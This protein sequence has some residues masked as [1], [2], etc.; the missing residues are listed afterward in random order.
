M[1]KGIKIVSTL[2][3]VI[4]TTEIVEI[5]GFGCGGG[6]S[7]RM[8]EPAREALSTDTDTE[9]QHEQL[10]LSSLPCTYTHKLTVIFQVHLC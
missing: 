8:M 9:Q 7:G 1:G 3:R 5:T 10:L 6:G 4:V 2:P